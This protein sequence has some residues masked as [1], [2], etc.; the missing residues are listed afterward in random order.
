MPAALIR[1]G[2]I[3]EIRPIEFTDIP[4]HKRHIWRPVVYEGEG[5]NVTSVVEADR[6]RVMRSYPPLDQLKAEQKALVD[7]EAERQR[8]RYITGGATKA[9]EYLEAKDQAVAV[10]QMGE[11]SA[12]ALANNGVAEFPVLA[13]SVPVEAPTLYAAAQLVS[14]RYEAYAS[15][16][17]QIKG[18]VIAAKAAIIAAQTAPEI[19]AV[20]G[21]I[22]WP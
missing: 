5:P 6:V 11:A 17:G 10:L 20:L 8:L 19:M 22:V 7:A 21:S 15:K 18:K 9:M 3:A 14:A 4:E 2:S 1:D 12:N 13:A 16:A